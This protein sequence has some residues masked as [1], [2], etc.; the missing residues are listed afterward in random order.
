VLDVNAEDEI[1]DKDIFRGILTLKLERRCEITL[2]VLFT[3]FDKIEV[4]WLM[5]VQG[6]LIID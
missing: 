3:L 4:L 1:L 5:Y 2:S 6:K